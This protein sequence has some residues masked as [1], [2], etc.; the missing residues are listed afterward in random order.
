MAANCDE[1]RSAKQAA[2]ETMMA[3]LLGMDFSS[4]SPRMA[5]RITCSADERPAAR[6]KWRTS[7]AAVGW[8]ITL[9]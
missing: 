9:P 8:L 6:K 4:D 7:T 2:N 5:A 3:V 1:R